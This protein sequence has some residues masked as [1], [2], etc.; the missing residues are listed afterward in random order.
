M[1][2]LTGCKSRRG[3]GV[4]GE[5]ERRREGGRKWGEGERRGREKERSP[6]QQMS[7]NGYGKRKG[8]RN[9]VPK[10]RVISLHNKKQGKTDPDWV[11][12]KHEILE[13]NKQPSDLARRNS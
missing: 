11:D 9:K 3:G 13:K 6:K 7:G 1:V 12:Q 4:G 2:Q 10:N 8:E 5:K